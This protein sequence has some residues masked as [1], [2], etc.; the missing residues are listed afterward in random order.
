VSPAEGGITAPEL[1]SLEV[2][3]FS[4]IA[5]WLITGGIRRAAASMGVVARRDARRRHERDTPLLG[6]TGI[7]V[8]LMTLTVAVALLPEG[9]I[10]FTVA[11]REAI[12]FL[13]SL[14]LIFGVG[15]I[16]DYVEL[17][18]PP[19]FAAQLVAALLVLFASGV[20][21]ALERT[22]LPP[23][24]MAAVLVVWVVGITNA[25]NMIDGLDGLCAGVAGLSALA[26]GA[27]MI[28]TGIGV[29][30]PLLVASAL[31]GACFGF[32]FHNFYPAKIFLGDSGSMLL[33]FTLAV[34]TAQVELKRSLVV[35]LSLPI[36][37]LGIPL[38]D[39]VLS[40]L[41]RGRQ[42]RSLFRGDRSHLHH[43]LQQV[44]LSHRAVVLLLWGASSYLNVMVFF[45]ALV[46]SS[47]SAYIYASVVL[48]VGF[49][50]LALWF[51]ERRLSVQASQFSRLF[52]KQ[53]LAYASRD[54][55]IVYLGEQV[56]R[57]RRSRAP[58]T[59]VVFDSTES[60]KQLAS[61]S[62]TKIVEF[63][64][65]LQAIL[66]SRLRG[67][68]LI[69]R[70]NDERVVAILAG[71]G[72][73]D[74]SDMGVIEHLRLRV[75]ELQE[76]FSIFQSHSKRPEGFRVLGFPKDARS[77]WHYLELTEKDLELRKAA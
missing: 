46:P 59:V 21:P 30:F 23:W 35:S 33:G 38:L 57:S 64:L 40:I 37:L 39:I 65:H 42:A 28:T 58:F 5:C 51:V 29:G 22:S 55:L 26:L 15:V 34:V 73:S 44:G 49:W 19:K 54:E 24:A 13:A 66:R 76:A 32:L 25:M 7:Y 47:A 53:D 48:T 17:K 2:F 61:L 52:L 3:V 18:A 9:M 11:P 8:I 41:R 45:L 16:D 20:P 62:P 12:A 63:H 4:A 72:G 36:V 69:A 56:D 14:T 1:L 77:I 67:T 71:A 10:G 60:M 50:L 31:A 70:V 75:K 6:G 43:R 68:D 27:T 74:A